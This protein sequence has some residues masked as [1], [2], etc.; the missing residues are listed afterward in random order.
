MC[1]GLPMRVLSA[2]DGRA[3]V[4][5]RGEEREVETLL[6]GAVEPGD[7]LLVFIDSARERLSAE[8]A[9]EV[10]ATLDLLADALGGSA[11]GEIGF[12]LPSAM[13]A[14]QLAALAGQPAPPQHPIELSENPA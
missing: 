9:A 10:D 8:R 11:L 5:G 1:I 2:R 3:R 6:V 14:A 13:S 12:E 4:A 7:W